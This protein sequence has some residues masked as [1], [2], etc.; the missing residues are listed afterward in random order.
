VGL[1]VNAMPRLFYHQKRAG[2]HCIGGWV[3]NRA[4]L[5]GCGKYHTHRVSIPGPSSP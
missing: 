5:D 1:V 2:T 3:G 4:S